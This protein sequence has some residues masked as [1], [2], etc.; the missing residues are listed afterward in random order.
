MRKPLVDTRIYPIQIVL[1]TVSE[2]ESVHR[3]NLLSA[4]LITFGGFVSALGELLKSAE[5][6]LSFVGIG[7]IVLGFCVYY[8]YVM[9]TT[10]LWREKS[11]PLS[12]K[13]LI[14]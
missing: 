4:I 8:R 1:V 11:V 7:M 14:E 5:L 6:G 2:V 12:S 10:R 9:K 13:F 3:M